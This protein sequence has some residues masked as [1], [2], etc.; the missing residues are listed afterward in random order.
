MNFIFPITRYKYDENRSFSHF[1]SYITFHTYHQIHN[2]DITKTQLKKLFI[3][4]YKND[5]YYDL[6]YDLFEQNHDPLIFTNYNVLPSIFYPY[7]SD[8][9]HYYPKITFTT[10]NNGMFYVKKLY[11]YGSIPE[12]IG[13][14]QQTVKY[15]I[16]EV[17]ISVS[18]KYLESYYKQFPKDGYFC[19]KTKNDVLIAKNLSIE[20]GIEGS[21]L[22]LSNYY[23]K[24][25]F[26]YKEKNT[27]ELLIKL[28]DVIYL[29]ILDKMT[30]EMIIKVFK[31][32]IIKKGS[33]LYSTHGG[34]KAYKKFE[35][36]S[37]K[38]FTVYPYP[39]S[40]PP[41]ISADNL[42]CIRGVLKKDTEVLNIAVDTYYNN[43]LVNDNYISQEFQYFDYRDPSY[44]TITSD[45][46]FRCFPN[47]KGVYN[48]QICNFNLKKILNP[49]EMFRNREIRTKSALNANQFDE[50]DRHTKDNG[51]K[52][53]HMILFKTPKFVNMWHV[54]YA[55]FLQKI[56]VPHFVYHT[57]ALLYNGKKTYYYFEIF[58]SDPT[59]VEY[60]DVNK[61][62]CH[63]L[64]NLPAT[65][66][67]KKLHKNTQ[68]KTRISRTKKLT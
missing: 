62:E 13:K 15:P 30:N 67:P 58:L 37:I 64:Y 24:N 5:K 23:L 2:P 31:K 46:F 66:S 36:Q 34:D 20:G 43:P 45:T 16:D 51:K 19:I 56:G 61:G 57:G 1:R 42:N 48:H 41:F 47:H 39:I 17:H 33:Y 38:F 27:E 40:Q 50:F 44:Q 60:I 9:F 12:F 63:K 35:E 6:Y 7:P 29:S 28:S 8:F 3:D 52:A 26:K 65:F 59:L 18:L 49:D 55:D 22:K 14:P 54:Y 10:N 25:K 68:K 32:E 21:I 11:E 53:L 4:C